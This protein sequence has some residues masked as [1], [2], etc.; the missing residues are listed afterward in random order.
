MHGVF[1]E[2]IGQIYPQHIQQK[3]AY[4]MNPF[5]KS[6]CASNILDI[7]TVQ[8]LLPSSSSQPSHEPNFIC[9]ALEMNYFARLFMLYLTRL[10]RWRI[11]KSVQNKTLNR[12]SILKRER[13]WK[14]YWVY[15]YQNWLPRIRSDTYGQILNWKRSISLFAGNDLPSL[16]ASCLAVLGF[17]HSRPQDRVHPKFVSRLEIHSACYAIF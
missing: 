2:C 9:V 11:S 1:A 14:R 4:Q 6:A 10:L 17:S 16:S 8:R 13:H 5:K 7:S 3:I 15:I 12:L